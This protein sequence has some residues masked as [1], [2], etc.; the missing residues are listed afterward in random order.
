MD[1]AT[2]DKFASNGPSGYGPGVGLAIMWVAAKYGP[3]T[4]IMARNWTM[5]ETRIDV[6]TQIGS[7]D[8]SVAAAAMASANGVM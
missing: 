6:R 2:I 1:T 3:Y 7:G 4:A 8:R 5:L